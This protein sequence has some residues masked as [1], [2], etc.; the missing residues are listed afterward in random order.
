MNSQELRGQLLELE[1]FSPDLQARYREEMKALLE[2][3]FGRRARIGWILSMLMGLS[4][5]VI[6]GI[7]AIKAPHDFPLLGRIGFILGAVYGA[8][9]AVVAFTIARR[10]SMNR[11]TQLNVVLGLTF[12]FMVIMMTLF[13]MQG[14]DMEDSLKG[15]KM[16]LGGLVFFVMFGLPSLV[17]MYLNRAELGIREHLLRLELQIAEIV[18]KQ[19]SEHN[20]AKSSRST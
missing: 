1:S 17:M 15:L 4:F 18:E 14:M 19:T 7:A 11:K 5:F 16:I 3:P 13:M 2:Q 20:N 9:W 6:F 8:V 12:G 10:G